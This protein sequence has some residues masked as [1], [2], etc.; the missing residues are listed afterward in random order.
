MVAPETPSVRLDRWLWAARL[1]KTR[2]L[3]AK[4]VAGGKVHVDGHAAKPARR[5]A[6]GE[7]LVVTKGPERL[8][9]DVEA[10]AEKRGPAAVART[11]YTETPQSIERRERH[12]EQRRLAA[13]AAPARRPERR[14]RRRLAEIKRG[15][16]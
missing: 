10:L 6:G 16:R 7:R 4:A 13:R 9:L 1:F 8:E 3:A 11:L 14:D 5:I 2:S 12:R 15:G